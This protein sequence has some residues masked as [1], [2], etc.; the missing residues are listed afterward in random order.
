MQSRLYLHNL[1]CCES[2]NSQFW[3]VVSCWEALYS[4]ISRSVFTVDVEWGVAWNCTFWVLASFSVLLTYC[5]SEY[6]TT[7]ISMMFIT[8]Q[9]FVEVLE[10]TAWHQISLDKQKNVSCW[11]LASVLFIPNR[12]MQH[13]NLK[14]INKWW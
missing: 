3:K 9:P 14:L 1:T 13:W 10:P 2:Q 4:S 8:E 6:L 12:W 5:L 7:C 11:V